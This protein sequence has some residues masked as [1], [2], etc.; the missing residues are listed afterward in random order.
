[1]RRLTYL[2]KRLHS[3]LCVFLGIYDRNSFFSKYRRIYFVH[4]L[5]VI[6]FD[7]V[8]QIAAFIDLLLPL[9]NQDV[10]DK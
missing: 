2:V 8:R 1:M 5:K 4:K 6:T 9:R 7:I 3:F 10:F